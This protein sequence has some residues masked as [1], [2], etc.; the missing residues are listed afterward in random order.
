MCAALSRERSRR[1]PGGTPSGVPRI[2]WTRPWRSS[3]GRLE[4]LGTYSTDM[5]AAPGL[6]VERFGGLGRAIRAKPLANF[7]ENGA[8][9]ESTFSSRS[10]HTA[11]PKSLSRT[12]SSDLSKS[13]PNLDP[14]N[15]STVATSSRVPAAISSIVTDVTPAVF[16]FTHSTIRRL[17][18]A[19]SVGSMSGSG[20]P[21]ARSRSSF[22]TS[23]NLGALTQAA[24]PRTCCGQLLRCSSPTSVYCRQLQL[25]SP[26]SWVS[27]AGTFHA[28]VA[29]R[30]SAS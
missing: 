20:E 19:K 9:Q 25:Q 17:V 1:S 18:G 29:R 4:L 14:R 15:S 5:T 22:R 30:V 23:S 26:C 12:R 6:I 8:A 16:R 11:R 3:R 28:P 21:L 10:S 13:S 27:L 2:L 7:S 24:F